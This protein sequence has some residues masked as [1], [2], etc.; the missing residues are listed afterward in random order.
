M[1]IIIIAQ[2]DIMVDKYFRLLSTYTLEM[3]SYFES[4]DKLI[5]TFRITNR[6][7]NKCGEKQIDLFE[8]SKRTG[9]TYDTKETSVIDRTKTKKKKPEPDPS[10]G[11][12]SEEQYARKR[13]RYLSNE[14]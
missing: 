9:M 11:Y 6:F 4:K 7:G 10:S 2:L 1:D 3:D 13:P 12:G 14:M 8:F 5:F